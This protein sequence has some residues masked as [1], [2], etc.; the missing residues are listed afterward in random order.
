MLKLYVKSI[1]IIVYLKIWSPS[2]K[3]TDQTITLFQPWHKSNLLTIDHIWIFGCI[4]YIFDEI[5]LKLNL[6]SKTWTGFL[7]GYEGHNKYCIYNFAYQVVYMRW[8]VIF[9]KSFISLAGL[10]ASP[11]LSNQ[12][13]HA[14]LPFPKL[15]ILIILLLDEIK[16]TENGKSNTTLEPTPSWANVADKDILSNLSD[17]P[18][19]S[20][21]NILVMTT[22]LTSTNIATPAQK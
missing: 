4:T 20:D 13:T 14:K 5:K 2:F 19:E 3:I 9:N 17:I 22:L 10:I 1:N 11:N 16:F 21:N 15:F 18:N 6:V 12:T 8:D 7:V